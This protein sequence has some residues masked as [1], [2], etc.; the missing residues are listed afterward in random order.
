MQIFVVFIEYIVDRLAVKYFALS[1]VLLSYIIFSHFGTS[2][3]SPGSRLS[4]L[5][6]SLLIKLLQVALCTFASK[7]GHAQ[8]RQ[9][10]ALF[11]CIFLAREC[12]S[13]GCRL[14]YT[15]HLC[16]P[17]SCLLLGQASFVRPS[18]N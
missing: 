2:F 7:D 13:S 17:P 11:N 9:V 6:R 16:P 14:P 4:C 18:R 12:N 5:A 1:I 15:S 10:G 8:C 3:Q